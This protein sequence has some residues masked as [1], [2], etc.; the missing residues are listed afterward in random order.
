MEGLGAN[1]DRLM[2]IVINGEQADSRDAV[3]LAELVERYQMAPQSVLI[4]HN[5]T[6]LHP[7]EWRQRILADGDRIEVIRVVAGG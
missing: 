7:R 3:N 4:E 6:A 5:G 1:P 2:R